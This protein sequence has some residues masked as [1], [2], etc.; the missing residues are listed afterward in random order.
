[1]YEFPQ[2]QD[3]GLTPQLLEYN[4]ASLAHL[5]YSQIHTVMACKDRLVPLE[6][7]DYMLTALVVLL[8]GSQSTATALPIRNMSGAVSLL[9]Q[10]GKESL[11][12]PVGHGH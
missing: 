6:L 5:V 12:R 1:M 9:L 8:S 10:R 11:F 7:W 3:Q 2:N 4:L